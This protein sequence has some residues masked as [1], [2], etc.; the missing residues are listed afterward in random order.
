LEIWHNNLDSSLEE[1][2]ILGLVEHGSK[3]AG[4]S[5][6]CLFSPQIKYSIYFFKNI[7]LP[8]PARPIRPEPRRSMVEGSG[9]GP[10]LVM[11]E[12]FWP[13]QFRLTSELNK[14]I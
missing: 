9:K 13:G 8:Y 10:G 1:E 7:F 2:V 3:K 11:S 12:G 5:L 4:L 6:P 14:S